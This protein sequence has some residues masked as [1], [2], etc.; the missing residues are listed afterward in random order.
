GET[1]QLAADVQPSDAGDSALLWESSDEAVATVDSEGLVTGIG[2][3]TATITVT[4]VDGGFTADAVIEVVDILI[5]GPISIAAANILYGN[6]PLVVEFTSEQSISN[7]EIVSYLWDFGTGD[8]S[9]IPNPTYTFDLAGSYEVTLTVIDNNGLSGSSSL[10]IEVQDNETY[11]ATM[12][13]MIISPNPS[14]EIAQV[15]IN[16]ETPSPLLGIYIYDSSGRLVK[17]YEYL[18]EVNGNGSYE[19]YIGDLRNEIYTVYAY[20]QGQDIPLVKKLVVRN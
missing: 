15:F 5:G 9:L 8:T 19:L 3:G 1:L 16:L 12:D 20:V 10:F 13:N 11:D 4:T 18:G 14:S 6:A 2:T 17:K 7:S